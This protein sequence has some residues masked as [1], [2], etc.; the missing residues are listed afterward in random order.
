M[1]FQEKNLCKS[2]LSGCYEHIDCMDISH[3]YH[4]D[5]NNPDNSLRVTLKEHLAYHIVFRHKPEKIGLSIKK[6]EKAIKEIIFRMPNTLKEA[7]NDD[8]RVKIAKAIED[9][10][11]KLNIK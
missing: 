10:E 3:F 7:A 5:N 4:S 6:N 9:W 8:F 11:R 1:E 2:E